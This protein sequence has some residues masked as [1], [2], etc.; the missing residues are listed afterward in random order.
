MVSIH[1]SD[2]N[3][4]AHPFMSAAPFENNPPVVI[5]LPCSSPFWSKIEAFPNSAV[6]RK[7]SGSKRQFQ[8]E[9]KL[10]AVIYMWEA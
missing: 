9:E 2:W 1:T 4:D 7:I 8:A 10:S 6:T 5:G 3:P